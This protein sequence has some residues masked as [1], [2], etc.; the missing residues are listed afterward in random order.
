MPRLAVDRIA[1][2]ERTPMAIRTALRLDLANQPGELAKVLRPIAQAGV[3]I[4]ALAGIASAH[5]AVV[6]A[7]PSDP[8]AAARALQ[9]A[10][11]HFQEVAVVVTWLPNRPGTLLKACEALA[12]AGINIESVYV[13][14]T[15]P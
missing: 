2:K 6:A 15:D 9:Q 8:A 11:I 1:S 5:S 7:L 3:N 13:V 14:S 12:T 10:G 4:H